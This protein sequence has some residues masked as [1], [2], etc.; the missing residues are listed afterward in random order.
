ML[1]TNTDKQIKNK[2]MSINLSKGQ[3]IDLR[4]NADNSQ[5]N[6]SQITIGLG[7]DVNDSGQDYD[8]DA[9]ALLLENGVLTSDKD[10]V[11]YKNKKHSSGTVWSMG[12][13][14]TGD[15]DGDD[16]QLIVKLDS[17]PSNFDTVV[18]YVSIY[19]G[20]SRRQ[21][22]SNV[23][24][25]FIRAVDANNKEIAKYSI[26]GD[27]SAKNMCS[28]VFAQAKRDGDSWVFEAIGTNYET[29]S[30]MHIAKLYQT[31]NIK[32]DNVKTNRKKIFGIF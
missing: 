11:S 17:I 8:L 27:K 32:T 29:D 4:K 1:G 9:C 24:N 21:V 3:K 5:N 30:L 10:I 31:K 13:N 22:F 18:F 6:L 26:S 14:L 15:G 28:L 7:W 23:S 25:A 16:E 12:D 19:S 2:N 20:K